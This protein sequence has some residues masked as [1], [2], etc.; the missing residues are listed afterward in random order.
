MFLWLG[1][2]PHENLK[3][4]QIISRMPYVQSFPQFNKFIFTANA[5][6]L[7][8]CCPFCNQLSV[9]GVILSHLGSVLSDSQLEICNLSFV[10]VIGL[11]IVQLPIYSHKIICA[12][13][14]RSKECSF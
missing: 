10:T 4:F 7:D 6:N 8:H 13:H 2:L 9:H 1:H 14:T 5:R 12:F 3:A 11:Q